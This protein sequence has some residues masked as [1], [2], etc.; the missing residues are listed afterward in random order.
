MSKCDWVGFYQIASANIFGTYIIT[1]FT[2]HISISK[3][4]R[5]LIVEKPVYLLITAF[6]KLVSLQNPS[7][8]YAY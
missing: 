6:Y 8:I 4:L 5:N 1:F 3:A 2:I 7:D